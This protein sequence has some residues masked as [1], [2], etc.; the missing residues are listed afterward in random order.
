MNNTDLRA[1]PVPPSLVKSLLAGFD[2]ISNHILLII[3]SIALDLFLWLGPRLS[4]EKLIV[5]FFQQAQALPE[6]QST[7]MS[8]MLE[9]S[10]LMWETLVERFN[11]FSALHTIPVGIPSLMSGQASLLTPLGTAPVWQVPTLL[12]T[13]GIWLVLALTG[14]LLGTLYFTLVS[15]A[16]LHGQVNLPQALGKWPWYAGQVI[17][18]ALFWIVLFLGLAVPFICLLTFLL[19]LGLNIGQ[20]A[21]LV[22]AGLVVWVFFPLVFSPHGIFTFHSRVWGTIM[23]SLQMTRATLPTTGLFLLAVVV[24]SQGLN[25]VW[26]LP[27]ESSWFLL[28]GII[29]HAF[30]TAGLLAA[31]FVYYRD[32]QSFMREKALAMTSNQPL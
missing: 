8:A 13:I 17:S 1:L 15:Q 12:A 30:I 6:A 3:F 16:V 26:Q 20:L 23:Q 2:I 24:L 32:A 31:S 21:I 27:E 28:V 9:N 11:L 19:V 22:Y 14:L 4:V 18:L 7:D 29:G 5:D 25:L 10:R